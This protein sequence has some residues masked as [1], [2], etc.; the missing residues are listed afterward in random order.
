M[1]P[2][3]SYNFASEFAGIF[4]KRILTDSVFILLLTIF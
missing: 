3:I 2:N 4:K 1:K